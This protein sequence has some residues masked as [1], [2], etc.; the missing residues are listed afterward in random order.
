MHYALTLYLSVATS[1]GN[2]VQARTPPV[3]DTLNECMA[4]GSAYQGMKP[5]PKFTC[6]LVKSD[7]GSAAVAKR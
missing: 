7:E 2:V 6:E 4:V 3:F 1:M 5:D